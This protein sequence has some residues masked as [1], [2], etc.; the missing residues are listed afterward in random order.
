MSKNNKWKSGLWVVMFVSLLYIHRPTSS[1]EIEIIHCFVN[2]VTR[3]S[4]TKIFIGAG[5]GFEIL[6]AVGKVSSRE[7]VPEKKSLQ[8]ILQ[9]RTTQKLAR[10]SS[11][12]IKHIR[13]KAWNSELSSFSVISL[14]LA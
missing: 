3:Y 1:S 4:N 14:V 2:S 5:F 13:H 11:L 8:S 10:E 6:E 7:T 12:L 9:V